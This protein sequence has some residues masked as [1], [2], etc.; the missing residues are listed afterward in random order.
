MTP[1]EDGGAGAPPVDS[2]INAP[3]SANLMTMDKPVF[4]TFWM[5]GNDEVHDFWEAEKRVLAGAI[6]REV[7]AQ[8]QFEAWRLRQAQERWHKAALERHAEYAAEQA[9]KQSPEGQRQAAVQFAAQHPGGWVS[10]QVDG[11]PELDAFGP[12]ATNPF[13]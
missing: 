12:D 13:K 4:E 8:E 7:T 5:I 3:A 2:A 9:H 11:I 1:R 6:A 10:G